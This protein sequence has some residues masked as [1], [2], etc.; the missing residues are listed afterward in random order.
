MRNEANCSYNMVKTLTSRTVTLYSLIAGISGFTLGIDIG[1]I[2]QLIT[3]F[4]SFNNKY[5]HLTNL[6]KGLIVS[7][8]NLGGLFGGLFLTKINYKKGRTINSMICFNLGIVLIGQLLQVV[9]ADPV[10]FFFLGRFLFGLGQGGNNVLCPLYISKICNVFSA[11][12]KIVGK[13]N[14]EMTKTSYYQLLTTVGILIGNVLSY[15]CVKYITNNFWQWRIP[16]LAYIASTLVMLGLFYFTVPAYNESMEHLQTKIDKSSHDTLIGTE[17]LDPSHEKK[18]L[19]DNFK[20][21]STLLRLWHGKPFYMWR[22][23]MGCTILIFQQF[24]GINYFFYYSAILFADIDSLPKNLIA[25][26]LSSINCIFTFCGIFIHKKISAKNMLLNGYFGCSLSMFI[27]SILGVLLKHPSINIQVTAHL[28]AAV[29]SIFI[30]FFAVF[31]GPTSFI[32]LEKILPEEIKLRALG[33]GIANSFNWI[34]GF[35]IG[36]LVPLLNSL[37]GLKVGYIFCGVTLIGLVFEY[38]YLPNMH[39]LNKKERENVWWTNDCSKCNIKEVKN[40]Y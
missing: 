34:T 18:G 37:I 27:F 29:A 6:Q 14:A 10:F 30:A 7:I 8:F 21:E 12:T 19:E 11:A 16:I 4:S 26:F 13:N 40:S 20:E 15:C 5:K 35:L 22:V 1:S 17:V 36:A 2:G 31:L 39:G 32:I 33:L 9:G 24:T 38:M 3:S 25:I 23:F 28:M